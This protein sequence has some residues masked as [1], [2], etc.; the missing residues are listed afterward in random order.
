VQE[1]G[2]GLTASAVCV[3]IWVLSGANGSFWPG[4]IIF[5]SLLPLA[6]DAW[7][8]LGPAPDLEAVERRLDS[9]RRRDRERREHRSGRHHHGPPRPPRPPRPPGLPR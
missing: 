3:A 2:G 8:L 5:F 9:G 6:R 7:S 4:W 1:G